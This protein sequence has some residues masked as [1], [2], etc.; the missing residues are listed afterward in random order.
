MKEV[1]LEEAQTQAAQM[2]ISGAW[3]C[4]IGVGGVGIN[5]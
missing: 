4:T 2:S 3:M 5:E 1:Q